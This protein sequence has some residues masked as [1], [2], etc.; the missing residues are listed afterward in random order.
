MSKLLFISIL[1]ILTF[2]A[3]G[4]DSIPV[5]KTELKYQG[6]FSSIAHY[7]GGNELPL[8]LSGRYLPQVNFSIFLKNTQFFKILDFFLICYTIF[9]YLL[10]KSF[11]N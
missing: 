8:L 5:I 1:S 2:Y 3:N 6:Q 7:N 11:F 9:N 4:Q 10:I